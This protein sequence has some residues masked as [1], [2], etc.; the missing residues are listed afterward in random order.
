MG[1][2][3]APIV[4]PPPARTRLPLG[5]PH[6]CEV[7]RPGP[8]SPPLLGGRL[9]CHGW[10][11][12]SPGQSPLLLPGSRVL[13][14]DPQRSSHPTRS[15]EPRGRGRGRGRVSKTFSTTSSRVARSTFRLPTQNILPASASQASPAR[16][17]A[18]RARPRTLNTRSLRIPSHTTLPCLGRPGRLP[19]PHFSCPCP[20]PPVRLGGPRSSSHRSLQKGYFI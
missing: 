3:K 10:S 18:S 1:L 14:F 5:P 16:C 11:A 12:Q 9:S 8:E 4:L 17:V 15:R 2:C 19:R 13:S 6:L 7:A 20:H